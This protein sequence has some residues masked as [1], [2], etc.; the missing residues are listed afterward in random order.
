MQTILALYPALP[1]I[2]QWLSSFLA[3]ST[4]Y[5]KTAAQMD[6]E[7]VSPCCQAQGQGQGQGQGQSQKSKVKSQ[8]Q[9]LR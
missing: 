1:P 7:N 9:T 6:R 2:L 4:N 8:N 3:G 5:F